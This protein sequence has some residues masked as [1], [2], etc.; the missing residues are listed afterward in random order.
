MDCVFALEA[1]LSWRRDKQMEAKQIDLPR[2][3]LFATGD[4][5]SNSDS[6]FLSFLAN[7]W[8]SIH[9]F[10]SSNA[11]PQLSSDLS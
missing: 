6:S 7:F 8:C 2:F 4:A 1:A 11:S 9:V 3:A 5:K 10:N